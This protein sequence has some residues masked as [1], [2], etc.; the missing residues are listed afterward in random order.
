ML[1][2]ALV[3][4]ALLRAIAALSLLADRYSPAAELDA[5]PLQ[6][7]IDAGEFAPA[8]ALALSASDRDAA[9]KKVAVAQV[10]AGD[11][12]GSLKTASMIDD[13]RA[14]AAALSS[15]RSAPFGSRGASG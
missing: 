7:A 9:L 8:L 6:G 3:A 14:V 5:S 10:Q 13:D 4:A 2:K 1:R 15:I 11:R 12:A